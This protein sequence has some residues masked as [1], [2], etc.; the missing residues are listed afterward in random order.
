MPFD[1]KTAAEAGSKGARN[2]WKDKTAET[3]RTE[4]LQLRLSPTELA[5]IK[6]K[7]I[8]KNLSRA[9]LVVRAVSAYGCEIKNND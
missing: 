7:A 3:R 4:L 5:E 8:A 6:T 9:E 1:K 2:R